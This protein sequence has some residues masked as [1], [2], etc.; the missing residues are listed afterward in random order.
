MEQT[1]NMELPDWPF[2]GVIIKVFMKV[3]FFIRYFRYEVIKGMDATRLC[4]RYYYISFY[5]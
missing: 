5:G 4:G 1:F 2:P 3:L